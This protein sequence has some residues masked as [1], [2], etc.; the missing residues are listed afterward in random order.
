M[1]TVMHVMALM[2]NVQYLNTT[3]QRFY[4]QMTRI[5]MI[6]RLHVL[7]RLIVLT[8]THHEVQHASKAV[9]V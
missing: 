6:I 8:H 2:M 9:N 5:L 3:I 7:H 4:I 1:A